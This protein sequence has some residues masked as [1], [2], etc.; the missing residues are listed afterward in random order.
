MFTHVY[1]CLLW[2]PHP[3]GYTYSFNAI[4]VQAPQKSEKNS[5]YENDWQ[6]NLA[7][8]LNFGNQTNPLE[9]EA[10]MRQSL[11]NFENGQPHDDFFRMTMRG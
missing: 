8:I 5:E 3:G 1:S 7:H 9:I 4:V 11:V 10:Q 6:S 2:S